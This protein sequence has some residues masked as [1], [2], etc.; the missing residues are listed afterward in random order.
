MLAN[1][2][3]VIIDA[4]APVGVALNAAVLSG[5][6]LGSHLPDLTGDDAPDASA[7]LHPGVSAHPVPVLKADPTRLSELHAAAAAHPD[8]DVHDINQ[9]ARTSRSYDQYLATMS[10]TKAEDLEYTALAI[11]GPRRAVDSLTGALALY[12]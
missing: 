11:H 8:L 4:D 5:I 2:I 10:G 6:S 9:V 7:Q 3:V 12:R 1:K